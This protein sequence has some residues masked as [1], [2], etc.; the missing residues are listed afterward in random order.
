MILRED[1]SFFGKEQGGGGGA[2]QEQ[3]GVTMFLFNLYNEK[4]S[5]TDFVLLMFSRC[6]PCLYLS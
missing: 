4:A 3:E 1:L 6:I 5:V 2:C